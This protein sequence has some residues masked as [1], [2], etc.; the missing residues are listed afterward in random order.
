MIASTNVRDYVQH[1]SEQGWDRSQIS[2]DINFD[3]LVSR[4]PVCSQPSS[5][6]LLAVPGWLRTPP[7]WPAGVLA[8]PG[9]LPLPTDRSWSRP[10]PALSRLSPAGRP[11]GPGPIREAAHCPDTSPRPGKPGSQPAWP[12]GVFPA[13]SFL[14]AGRPDSQGNI[15]EKSGFCSVLARH[16]S[17]PENQM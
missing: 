13:G 3:I 16:M 8:F 6:H 9:R 2:S 15:Q 1:S 11:I 5:Q 10:F 4:P 7:G 17:E 14:A 12:G